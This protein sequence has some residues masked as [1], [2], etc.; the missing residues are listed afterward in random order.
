M[1][2]VMVP[3]LACGCGYASSRCRFFFFP[4][5]PSLGVLSR[6]PLCA[7][8]RRPPAAGRSLVARE[9]E[10]QGG[11]APGVAPDPRVAVDGP[12]AAEGA[13][14]GCSHLLG[15]RCREERQGTTA[16]RNGPGHEAR[17]CGRRRSG[18]AG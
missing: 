3:A 6:H 14:C 2:A 10:P 13:G 18:E 5:P 4:S 7:G 11:G 15:R 12:N 8:V 1:P 17:V 16:G 9:G